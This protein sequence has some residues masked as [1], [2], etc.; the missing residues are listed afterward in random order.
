VLK[1]LAQ[2]PAN[3]AVQDLLEMK[4]KEL[5]FG[6]NHR[7]AS[8]RVH[9]L[10]TFID[11]YTSLN[12]YVFNHFST[13]RNN[14]D[15]ARE[16]LILEINQTS[17][18]LISEV[19]LQ[20]K[21]C[22]AKMSKCNIFSVKEDL[23]SIKAD[24]AKWEKDVKYL[25]VDHNLW[26]SISNICGRHLDALNKSRSAFEEEAFGNFKRLK[27]EKEISDTFIKQLTM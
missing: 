6:Y 5:N 13:Q 16:K 23:T 12:E 2:F 10:K 27:S 18:R 20:E 11:D 4:I 14:I 3:K 22:K 26:K 9:E 24:L 19:N 25:V 8:E 17:D 7:N 21:E 15:L 1:K